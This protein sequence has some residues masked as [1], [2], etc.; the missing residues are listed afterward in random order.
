MNLLGQI[1]DILNNRIFTTTLN[2]GIFGGSNVYG[3][4]SLG[5]PTDESPSRPYVNDHGNTKLVDLSDNYPATI[6]HRLLNIAMQNDQAIAWGDSD[7]VVIAKFDMISVF[8]GNP[9]FVKYTNEDLIL[10]I[11]TALNYTL[12]S[13]DINGVGL[14]FVRASVQRAN[15]NSLQVFQGEYSASAS[16]PMRFDSVYFGVYYQIEIHATNECLSCFEC[17]TNNIQP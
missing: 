17:L 16:C 6:Y 2:D 10:K 4:A 12:T 3:L 7:G 11:S 13:G 5:L 15:A 14:R 1:V 8:Y 9:N